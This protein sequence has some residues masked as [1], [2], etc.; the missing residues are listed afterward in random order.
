M[1][2]RMG[3]IEMN[4]RIRK[5]RFALWTIDEWDII[6]RDVEFYADPSS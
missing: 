4:R 2:F 1:I 3:Q 6:G 5:L